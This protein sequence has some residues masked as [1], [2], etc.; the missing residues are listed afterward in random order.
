MSDD[1]S[2]VKRSLDDA[3]RL[4]AKLGIDKGAKRQASGF[5]VCCPVHGEKNP[6]CS[7][8]RGRDGT[9]RVHCFACDWSSDALGLIAAVRGVNVKTDFPAVLAEAASLA[10]VTLD[11]SGRGPGR[12]HQARRDV[13][14]P[15]P[16]VERP[17][18]PAAEVA[19]LWDSAGPCSEDREA[20]AT[21][22]W[23]CIDPERVDAL[24]LAR[25]IRAGQPLPRWASYQGRTW[26]ETGHRLLVR[27]WDA[28]GTMRTVRAWR[29]R[30]GDTPKRLPPAGHRMSG[31]V[32]A[33][34]PGVAML[35]GKA[36]PRRLGVVEGEPD[37]TV[38][39]IQAP[40]EA[41]LGVFSG[42]WRTG[43][44]AAKVPSGCEVVI[45]THADEAGDRYAREVVATLEDRCPLWR[46][47][48]A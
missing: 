10:G 2:E 48:V 30:D 5:L 29:V 35:M 16:D 42:S 23:R 25:V 27:C 21:L 9:V 31:L 22:A 12:P 11:R 36:R 7:V 38:W 14:P 24:R 37:A 45:R 32:L 34:R 3:R 26:P 17:Y 28:T 33:N 20:S 46:K 47:A 40:D 6:S 41:V 43:N 44:F 39:M 8:T 19:A 13:A 15:E 1:V 18:P 4:C